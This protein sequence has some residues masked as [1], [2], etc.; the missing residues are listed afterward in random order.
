[1]NRYYFVAEL[2]TVEANSATEALAKLAG[3]I[4]EGKF[5]ITIDDVD[6]NCI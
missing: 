1:M 4:A 2:P 3:L 6:E 5:T